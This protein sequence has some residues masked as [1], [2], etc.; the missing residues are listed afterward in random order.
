MSISSTLLLQKLQEVISHTKTNQ[1]LLYKTSIHN[2]WFTIAQ[3]KNAL[4]SWEKSL[5]IDSSSEWLKRETIG[6][7]ELTEKSVGLILAG[8]LPLVG[9]HDVLC[10]LLV[11]HKAIVKL[12]SQDSIL[13][14][15][16]LEE[17][18]TSL[19]ILKDRIILTEGLMKNADAYIG[20]GSNNSAR[21]FEY[22]F[23]T[24]PHIIRKNRN[25]VAL[26]EED[27]T[28]QELEAL[29]KDVFSYFGMGCRN[30]THLFLPKNFDFSRLYEAWESY[31]EVIHHH[32]YANNYTYHKAILLMNLDKHLDNGFLM[33]V[34][35][36]QISSPVA[37]LGYSFYENRNEVIDKIKLQLDNIQCV[38]SR[39]LDSQSLAVPYGK[40]QEP[41]LWDYADGVNTVSFLKAI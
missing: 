12:S 7:I 32:K 30:V 4:E 2:P 24:K 5:T 39:N 16:I 22:Y 31:N 19:P 35:R 18:T 21:Y 8:N 10:T 3:S 1:E 9:L 41:T 26:I 17:L 13:M 25:S 29:G 20:T 28:D 37:M 36:E 6:E 34:E 14:K 38:A 23:N 15:W 40:T 27:Y 11:G 33:L